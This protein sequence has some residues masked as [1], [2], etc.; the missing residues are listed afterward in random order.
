M[1][2]MKAMKQIQRGAALLLAALLLV[3]MASCTGGGVDM[4]KP[5]MDTSADTSV[6]TSE[7]TSADTSVNTD[8]T[9][10]E[11]VTPVES[12]TTTKDPGSVTPPEPEETGLVLT[13][14]QQVLASELGGLNVLAIGDSLFDG[15]YLEGRQQWI[16]LMSRACGWNLTNLG[17][18]GWTVAYNPEAYENPSN[19]R[20]SMAKH[21]LEVANYTYGSSR[22]FLQFNKSPSYGDNQPNEVDM[23]LLEG[24]TN[25]YGWGIPLGEV[26]SRDIGTL[27][28]AFNLMIEHL[29]KT[30]PHAKVVL[31]TSW[32]QP[33]TRGKDGAQRMDFVA[34]A[35][36]NIKDTN[37]AENSRVALLDAGDPAVS[38]VDMT[39]SS[40]RLQYSKSTSDG[41][42][43]NPE[44]MK[45]VA[46]NLLSH[47]HGLMVAQPKAE[48][49]ALCQRLEGLDVLAIGDSLTDGHAVR[50]AGQWMGL[51]AK[52]CA[53]NMTNIGRGAR[54][55]AYNPSVQASLGG[56]RESIW[57]ELFRHAD[58]FCYNTADSRYTNFGNTSGK[59]NEEI[60][61]V[62]LQGGVN[63]FQVNIPLGE[64]DSTSE[65]DLIGAWR[66][67]IEEI[68]VRYPNAKIVLI[69]TWKFNE[70]RA[71]D[72]ANRTD[73][74]QEALKRIYAE[75]YVENERVSLIDAGDPLVSRVYVES[76][77]FR[78][79]FCESAG[80]THH[81][82]HQGM[83]MM[84]KAMLP[85][86]AQ[87]LGGEE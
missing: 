12:Q 46:G 68:L 55:V 43:L 57:E 75:Y 59:S 1:K 76:D 52:D 78:R 2:S 19:Q 14:E 83:A 42:H 73:F 27:Y 22:F 25:D 70:T 16:A 82:N 10:G 63:D 9:S 39:S 69:T 30:Y 60:D 34:N 56:V 51:L 29:L 49:D 21:L 77:I 18:D 54:T 72:G 87:I 81:L 8:E 26:S 84:A 31:V 6:N 62:F 15:D 45:L 80:D 5:G 86:L 3:G 17:R 71:L 7:T 24:G 67:I 74:S 48:Y 47:I 23:I 11:E 4:T 50:A 13:P 33:G 36:K 40:F 28:G 53:W 61:L 85:L 79:N 35:M 37:Y 32:H 38:G 66:Q 20:P 58:S 64:I 41:N 65:G 44:G